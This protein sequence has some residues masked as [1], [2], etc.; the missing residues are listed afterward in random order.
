MSPNH[1]PCIDASK[2]EFLDGLSHHLVEK[3]TNTKNEIRKKKN[4]LQYRK[5]RM[6]IKIKGHVK[7]IKHQLKKIWN[8]MV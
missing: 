7:P 1:H 3:K 4:K 5:D 6:L 8:M 2:R